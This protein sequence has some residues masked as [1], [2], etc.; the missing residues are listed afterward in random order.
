M[1]DARMRAWCRTV[2][3]LAVVLFN[4]QQL[5][6]AE[7]STEPRPFHPE[8][9]CIVNVL[10]VKGPHKPD[11]V[12]HDARFGWKR[13]VS[14]YKKQ[15][16]KEKT[17]VSLELLISAQGA[18]ANARSLAFESK[19]SGLASCLVERLPGLSMPKAPAD[20]KAEIEIILSPGDK[21]PKN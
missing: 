8:P 20:S 17:I 18:V 19:D 6:N 15:G 3:L 9:R 5:A 1:H 21:P 2:L 13:I 10:D 4:G 11:R 16:A 12:Q 14:C 7:D